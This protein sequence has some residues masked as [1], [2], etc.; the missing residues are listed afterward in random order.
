LLAHIPFQ[1][2]DMLCACFANATAV[3]NGMIFAA[4]K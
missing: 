3:K 2:E 4:R 1:K